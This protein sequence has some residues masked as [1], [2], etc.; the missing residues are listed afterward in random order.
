MDFV[1]RPPIRCLPHLSRGSATFKS[2]PE[3][4]CVDEILGFDLAGE[5]EHVYVHFRKTSQNTL[6]VKQQLARALGLHERDIG[7]AG[8]KDRH[9]VTTQWFSLYLPHGASSGTLPDIRNVNID[10]V[11][12]LEVTRHKA[13]LRIGAH[14]VSYTHLTLPTI[15]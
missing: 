1:I 4:F 13:K 3:D 7:H 14:P 6:W 12:W 10:G 8:L 5:G 15:A 2:R 11:E 9:A